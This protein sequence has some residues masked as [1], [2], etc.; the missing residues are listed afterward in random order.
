MPLEC[1]AVTKFIFRKSK[2]VDGRYAGD[3]FRFI[4]DI[5]IFRQ[6]PQDGGCPPWILDGGNTTGLDWQCF[7]TP[8]V[9][10]Q[11]GHHGGVYLFCNSRALQRHVLHNLAK[12]C[13]RT[14]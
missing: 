11:E 2:M 3:P 13:S 4:T 7:L 12:F 9:K 6:G 1:T 14:Y 10:T 5:A 8:A